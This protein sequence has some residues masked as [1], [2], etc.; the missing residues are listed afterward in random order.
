MNTKVND[1]SIKMVDAM[2]HKQ[3]VRDVTVMKNQV[4]LPSVFPI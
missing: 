3:Y 2:K 4:I 1:V